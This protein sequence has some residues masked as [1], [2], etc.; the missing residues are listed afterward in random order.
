MK[1]LLINP[2]TSAAMTDGM[3]ASARAV[4]APDTHAMRERIVAM[5]TAA[6]TPA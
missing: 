2:N 1:L 6:A 3:T 5:H 4:A